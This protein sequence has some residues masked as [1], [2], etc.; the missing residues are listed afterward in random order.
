MSQLSCYDPSLELPQEGGSN[1]GPQPM[2]LWKI[3]E[4][5]LE[6]S[7]NMPLISSNEV[8]DMW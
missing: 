3:K 2:F 4:I 6:L 7:L 1:E 5:I 8:Y